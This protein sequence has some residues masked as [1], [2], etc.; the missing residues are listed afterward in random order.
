MFVLHVFVCVF[1]CV[2]ETERGIE[3]VLVYKW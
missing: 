1:V 3:R 2:T